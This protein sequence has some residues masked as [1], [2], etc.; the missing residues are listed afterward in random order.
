MDKIKVLYIEDDAGQRK[1]F[2]E[3]MA[4]RSFKVI[5]AASGAAALR[6]FKKT[7]AD[8]VL[9]DLNMS[10]MNGLE[11]LAEIREDES[12]CDVPVVVL[13]A[14]ADEEFRL[15]SEFLGV[16]GYIAK[17]VDLHKFLQIVRDLKKHWHSDL[18]LPALE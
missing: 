11:V 10:K 15:Q 18:V 17:P 5:S 16:E 13:T 4:A 1:Q 6:S 3:Q 12:L 9:C 7:R 8:V 14:A 2:A